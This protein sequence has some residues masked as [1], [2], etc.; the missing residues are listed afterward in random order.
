MK[1]G[2]ISLLV[3]SIL[4]SCGPGKRENNGDD[5]PQDAAVDAPCITALTG[6]VFAPNGTLPLYNVLVYVPFSTPP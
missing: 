1:L 3:L 5:T 2:G 6:K 4:A